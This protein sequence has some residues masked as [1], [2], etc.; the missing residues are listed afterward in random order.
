M[1]TVGGCNNTRCFP[2][3]TGLP[4]CDVTFVWVDN[5]NGQIGIEG[6]TDGSPG[7]GVSWS[8]DG[9]ALADTMLNVTYT[10]TDTGYHRVCLQFDNASTVSNCQG[11]YC[12]DVYVSKVDGIAPA[13]AGYDNL[14]IYPNPN[15]GSFELSYD[16]RNNQPATFT[17]YNLQGQ[18]LFTKLLDNGANKHAI[19]LPNVA[20]GVYL[21]KLRQNNQD[22]YVGRIVIIH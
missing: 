17:L 4:T 13:P 22:Q 18:M 8:V 19:K 11:G 10:F 7:T 14:L 2:I 6:S 16:T 20:N 9:D 15:N 3:E 12:Q 5:G 1:D 21:Y